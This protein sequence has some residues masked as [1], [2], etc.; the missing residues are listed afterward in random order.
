L[1]SKQRHPM[2]ME[3]QRGGA[4]FQTR[5]ACHLTLKHCTNVF[6]LL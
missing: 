1:D 6:E 2:T 5:H 4:I 3:H